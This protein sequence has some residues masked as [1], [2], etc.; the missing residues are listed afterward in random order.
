M[1]KLKTLVCSALMLALAALSFNGCAQD[2][3]DGK[4]GLGIIWQG[5]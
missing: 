3:T 2:G 4:D 1:K 5:A